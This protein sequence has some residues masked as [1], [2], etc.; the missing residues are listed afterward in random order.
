L[1]P[2]NV[3]DDLTKAQHLYWPIDKANSGNQYGTNPP[4]APTNSAAD[5]LSDSFTDEDL[6]NHFSTELSNIA[7]AYNETNVVSNWSMSFDGEST[8]TNS[9]IAKYAR[10]TTDLASGATKSP[11]TGS[12]DVFQDGD[13]IVADTPATY[14]IEIVDSEG[15]TRTIVDEEVY[16][17]VK[18]SSS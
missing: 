7:S 15:V 1:N 6:N 12:S 4:S 9:T 18:H 17:V 2:F 13:V 11:A 10:D 14:K 3:S 8:A 16:G 5:I